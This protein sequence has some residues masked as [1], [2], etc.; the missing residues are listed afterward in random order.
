MCNLPNKYKKNPTMNRHIRLSYAFAYVFH[1]YF[2][3]RNTW[4]TLFCRYVTVDHYHWQSP[5]CCC[6]FFLLVRKCRY[7]D[8]DFSCTLFNLHKAVSC[9]FRLFHVRN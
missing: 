8:L 3:N 4:Q 9:F 1:L 5:C 2:L 6:N 7:N